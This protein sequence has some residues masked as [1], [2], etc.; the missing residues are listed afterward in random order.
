MINDRNHG[1][2]AHLKAEEIERII[3]ELLYR[4]LV[5]EKMKKL[6]G[7]K[8]MYAGLLKT[9]QKLADKILLGNEPI[10]INM[11]ESQISSKSKK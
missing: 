9:T 10:N 2:C 11:K 4:R 3:K 6:S 7:I 1:A 5:T 8:G